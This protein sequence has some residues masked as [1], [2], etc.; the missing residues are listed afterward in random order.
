[1]QWSADTTERAHITEVKVPSR[2]GNNQSYN[3]QICRWLDRSEK[4]RNFSLAI[5]ITQSQRGRDCDSLGLP[6]EDP[7]NN[8]GQDGH[9]DS[10]DDGGTDNDSD[11]K[12]GTRRNSPYGLA[13]RDQDLFARSVRL[14]NNIA[15]S[16]PV[17]LRVFHSET[18]AFQLNHLP[19]LKNA[20]ID[21]VAATFKIPDLRPALIDYI[22]RARNLHSAVF[23]LGQRRTSP[24]GTDLPF[25]HLNVWYSVRMQMQ[26]TDA[27]GLTDPQRVCASPPSKEWPLGRYDAALV[28]N[29][30][31][32]G[33]GLGGRERP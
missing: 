10:D 14:L 7:I 4:H 27:P 17:P 22:R 32:L 19:S 16:T 29:G 3:P 5:S 28:S 6:D 8:G 24:S 20:T 1:M 2:S 31:A 25:T 26:T 30:T 9:N 18:T 11:D 23:R 13:T 21:D 15:P 12:D 33:P